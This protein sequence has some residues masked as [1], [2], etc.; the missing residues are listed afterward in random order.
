MIGFLALAARKSENDLIKQAVR[1][2]AALRTDEMWNFF[3]FEQLS[4]LEECLK[5]EPLFD[6]VSWDV[7]LDGAIEK[8]E[9]LRQVYSQA[10]L[11]VVAD[12]SISPMSYLRPGIMPS[13]LL[14]KPFDQENLRMVVEEMMESFAKRFSAGEIPESFAVAT[15][16]GTQYIPFDKIYYV[17]AREKKVYIRTRNEEYGFYDTIENVEKKLPEG[18][19]RCH[20]SYIANM[21]LVR[22]V[23]PSQ[24][25]M[26]MQGELIVPL[27]RSYKKIV[28]EFFER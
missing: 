15:R 3:M 23:K 28:K 27:S 6:I 10:F 5:Q 22:A 9:S 14:L 19:C 8:L 7:T 12:A 25:L 13:S 11:M 18:F 20:R 24:N 17:E 21:S 2:Q 26:E 1:D 4:K 16:E